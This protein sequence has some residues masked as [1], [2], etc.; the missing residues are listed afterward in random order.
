VADA[1]G[2]HL[3]TER[4]L[5]IPT[6]GALTLPDAKFVASADGRT[7]TAM[8]VQMGWDG[9]TMIWKPR[10]H[11]PFS[12]TAVVTTGLGEEVRPASRIAL[13]QCGRIP[14]PDPS[15]LALPYRWQLPDEQVL[16]TLAVMIW[17]QKRPDVRPAGAWP[18]SPLPIAAARHAFPQGIETPGH[19]ESWF[20][21]LPVEGQRLALAFFNRLDGKA[22]SREEASVLAEAERTG[23]Q[24]PALRAPMPVVRP[25]RLIL[26]DSGR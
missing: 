24:L 25:T 6:A 14:D 1:A 13:A 11:A 10:N 4:A 16:R 17:A 12:V 3:V 19:P 8:F 7:L 22:L 20:R 26:P 18:A 15:A 9:Q 5:P 2:Q 23:A 21:Y